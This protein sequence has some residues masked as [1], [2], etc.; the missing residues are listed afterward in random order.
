MIGRGIFDVFPDNPEDAAATGVSRLRVSLERVLRTG[1]ADTMGV[2]KYD[3]RRPEAEG[4]AFEERYWSPVNSP[5]L[6]PGRRLLYILHAVQ[7]VTEFVRLQELRTRQHEQTEAMKTR[8]A[9]MEAEILTRSR[10]LH[11]AR[12]AA[13]AANRA[14]SAFLANM[15]HEIRTPMNAILGYAQLL[16][17]DR[18]LGPEQREHVEVIHRSGDHLLDLINDVLE[19]SKIEAGHRKLNRGAVDLQP[20]LGD[21][22]RMFRLRADAKGLAFEIQRSPE[23]PGTS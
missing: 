15:S 19:M 9:E 20:L 10:E 21:I 7:D 1:A 12:D 17:R 16:L 18:T 23:V 13:D 2:Q 8:A 11:V 5:V 6:G 22:E 4:G 3:V 14:K